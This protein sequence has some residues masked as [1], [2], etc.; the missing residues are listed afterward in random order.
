M[1]ANLTDSPDNVE[2]R[3]QF[4]LAAQQGEA[5]YAPRKDGR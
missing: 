1:A 3:R 5:T 2:P 4:P